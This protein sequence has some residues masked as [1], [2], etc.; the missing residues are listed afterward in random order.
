MKGRCN[1]PISVNEH[2][3]P[4]RSSCCNLST[5]RPEW[6]PFQQEETLHKEVINGFVLQ[7][8]FCDPLQTLNLNDI[9]PKIFIKWDHEWSKSALETRTALLW[10]H[11]LLN[12]MLLENK[13]ATFKLPITG[14][15]QI[16][17]LP[18]KHKH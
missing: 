8:F 12:L 10:S 14:S 1:S 11:G 15:L 4:S 17:S 13:S 5:N 18:T 3:L 16:L 9:I 6:C 7:P 2:R